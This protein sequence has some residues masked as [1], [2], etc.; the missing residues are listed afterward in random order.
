[1]RILVLGA[2]LI[3]TTL[4]YELMQRGHEVTVVDRQPEG[5]RECSFSNGGQ[6]SYSHAEPWASPQVLLKILQ[7]L[8]R[9]DAPLVF[10][11]RADPAMWSWALKFLKHCTHARNLEGTRTMLR[12]SLYSRECFQ[13]LRQSVPVEFDFAETGTLHIYKSEKS[14]ERAIRHAEF[15]K[16]LGCSYQVLNAEETVTKEPALKAIQSTLVGSIHFPLDQTGDAYRFTTGLVAHCKN[17]DFRFNTTI[18][19]IESQGDSITGVLTN[20][21][22]L[23]AD[24]YVVALGAESPSLLKKLGI[25]LPIYP[26]KGYSISLPLDDNKHS[27]RTSILDESCKVVATRLGEKLRIAGTAEFAGYNTE[28]T[29]YRINTIIR[30]AQAL[31][32]ELD[33][34]NEI[35]RWACLRPAVP[36][37]IPLLGKTPLKNL[38]LNTGHGSLGWT[39]AAGSAMIVADAIEDKTLAISLDGMGLDR[40][41]T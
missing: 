24:A 6:L 30:A 16:Q 31:F 4:A 1:M 33:R 36:D 25:R 32:P 29:D 2:G 19:A 3:G 7:W 41:Y 8:G 23:T 20:Q 9:K 40:F 34:W 10:R 35:S 21:G 14:L 28:P 12:L 11:F 39:L 38:F 17:V 37:G 18:T 22:K 13:R 26:L 5:A 15:Q 27:F